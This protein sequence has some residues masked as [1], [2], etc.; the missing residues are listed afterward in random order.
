MRARSQIERKEERRAYITL[1]R[2]VCASGVKVSFVDAD[3]E[4]ANY[5]VLADK[6]I[7]LRRGMTLRRALYVLAHEFG[8]VQSNFSSLSH[9]YATYRGEPAGYIERIAIVVEEID[10]WAWAMD[11]IPKRLRIDC[12]CYAAKC[13]KT[14]AGRKVIET[15]RKL[16]KKRP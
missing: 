6:H 16:A 4:D 12:E 5:V 8:H 15:A 3:E 7:V 11:F 2:A 13:L 1:R 10:A 14:Y 9:V